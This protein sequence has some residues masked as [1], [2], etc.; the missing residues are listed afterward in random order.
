MR[1]PI[2]KFNSLLT[3]FEHHYSR[4]N[5]NSKFSVE[6]PSPL[7]HKSAISKVSQIKKQNPS[8]YHK[9]NRESFFYITL[10][11]FVKNC[12]LLGFGIL[13]SLKIYKILHRKQIPPINVIISFILAYKILLIRQR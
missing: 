8:I 3:S 11:S 13:I 6:L 5:G 12:F 2:I 1:L 4:N 10:F 9:N 7:L